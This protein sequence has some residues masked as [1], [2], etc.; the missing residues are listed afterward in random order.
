MAK[1]KIP[2]RFNLIGRTI[3]VYIVKGLRSED[4]DECHGLS[5]WGEGWIKLEADQK[6]EEMIH[7]FFHEV[8]HLVFQAGGRLDL[9]KSEGLV[10]SQ[11]A[12]W[13]QLILTMTGTATARL[14]A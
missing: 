9:D 11:G 6:P 13:M 5:M 4:D 2:K 10:D 3:R 1:F 14:R 7:T 12:L 8:Q